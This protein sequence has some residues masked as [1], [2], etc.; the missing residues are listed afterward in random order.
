MERSASRGDV[1]DLC[2]ALD[3]E[4]QSPEMADVVFRGVRGGRRRGSADIR[5]FLPWN[6]SEEKKDELGTSR[7]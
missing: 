2:H 6:M 4:A 3:V 5:P 7:S 1:F